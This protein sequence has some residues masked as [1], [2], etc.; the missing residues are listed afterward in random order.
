[1]ANDTNR[2][3]VLYACLAVCLYALYTNV[4]AFLQAFCF[5]FEEIL[6]LLLGENNGLRFGLHLAELIPCC[7]KALRKGNRKA[8]DVVPQPFVLFLQIAVSYK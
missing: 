1:M 3:R 8:G 2:K 5:F 4:K 7:V 6:S